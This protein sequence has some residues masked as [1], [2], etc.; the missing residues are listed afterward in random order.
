ML[1]FPNIAP[2]ANEAFENVRLEGNSIK[3][4]RYD[5]SS[6][7]VQVFYADKATKD[8]SGHTII[9][10]YVADVV[11]GDNGAII[12]KAADGNT[13]ATVTPTAAS[14]ASDTYGNTIA[15]YVK[16]ITAPNDSNYV[17]VSHGTGTAE[18]LT[19]NYSNQ[20]WKDTNGNVIKN[21]YIKDLEC[22][23]D[24]NDGH[25][26]LVAYNGDN[27]QA[28][29]FRTEIKAYSAQVADEAAHAVTADTAQSSTGSV[30]SIS[31][32]IL[33]ISNGDGTTQNLNLFRASKVYITIADG[34]GNTNL[35]DSSFTVGHSEEF[36][37]SNYSV[38]GYNSA[39]LAIRSL[40][41]IGIELQYGTNSGAEGCDCPI[42]NYQDNTSKKHFLINVFDLNSA[43][44]KV[45]EID[46]P[47]DVS[48]TPENLTITRLA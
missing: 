23:E 12:F 16:T 2:N 13:I 31:R 9:S 1:R 25:Y 20:A 3:F 8:S 33:T 26:K 7:S 37:C 41:G 5:G 47:A 19:V 27:P 24:E 30:S 46:E 32:N 39:I 38:W 29:L 42:Y 28:E 4:I 6:A 11:E 48:T 34:A 35:F 15:D 40:G 22:V 18:T 36:A 10:T 14:A 44:M 21:T 43:A 45:F 17:T